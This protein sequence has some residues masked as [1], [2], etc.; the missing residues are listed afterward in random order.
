MPLPELATVWGVEMRLDTTVSEALDHVDEKDEASKSDEK[1]P[2]RNVVISALLIDPASAEVCDVP[3][4]AENASSTAC[5]EVEA[6]DA[7]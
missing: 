7:V 1:D 6:G 5:F 3:K 4:A 2:S